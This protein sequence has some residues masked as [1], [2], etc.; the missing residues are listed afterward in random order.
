MSGANP[1]WTACTAATPSEEVC[2]GVDND[3]DGLLDGQDDSLSLSETPTGDAQCSNGPGC[4]GSWQCL[5][6]N[7]S[8]SAQT[9]SPEVC[10]QLDND[11][12]G[13]KDEDFQIDGQYLSPDHCGGCGVA[14]SVVIA[15]SVATS[16]ELLDGNPTCVATECAPGH[17]PF[18]GGLSCPTLPDNLCQPCT[19]NQDCLV[20][21][22]EC[23][24]LGVENVCGRECSATSPY[25]PDC[26]TG[27]ACNG[28]QCTPTGNTCICGT[29]TVGLE[30]SCPTGDCIGIQV[31]EEDNDV[32]AFTSCSAEGVIP[33]VCDGEDNDC[34]GQVDEGFV[35][36]AG[37]YTT[38]EHCGGCYNNCL[39]L[40]TE[41]EHHATGACVSESCE[42]A[43]C[44]TETLNGVTYEW[45][46]V[47][48]QAGDGCECRRVQGN[49]SE[50]LPDRVFLTAGTNTPAF[51]T[52][53]TA[54]E[55]ANCDGVDGVIG[56]AL[57]VTSAAPAGGNGSLET[58]FRTI[59]AAMDAAP[60]A[61][62]Q[63]ILVAGGAYEENI[64]LTEGLKLHGGYAPDFLSRNI[65]T[66]VTEIRGQGPTQNAPGTINAIALNGDETV[67]SGFLITGAD[68]T[69]IGETS[70]SVYVRNSSSLFLANNR[71]VGGSGSPGSPGYSGEIGYGLL[72]ANGSQLEGNNGLNAGSCVS[73][74]CI[75]KSKNGGQAG[76]NPVCPGA[77]GH[78][79]GGVVCP[80]YNTPA[81][82]PADP[83]ID[84]G[85]G[86]SWTLD[87]GS[88]GS[89]TGHATEAGY[90]SNIKK[91]NG[92]DGENGNDGNDGLQGLGCTNALGVLLSSDLWAGGAGSQGATAQDGNPG[93]AGGASGGIDSASASEM[94]PGVNATSNI[95]YKLG[96]TGGGG[97][98]AG[99]GGTGGSGGGTGR[100]ECRC[101]RCGI[102]GPV[103]SPHHPGQS[104]RAR[105][106]R[107]WRHRRLR[108]RRRYRRRRWRRR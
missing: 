3:C 91:L 15:H 104:N 14:C 90:P 83:A 65:V 106:G 41:A 74:N 51:P 108:R 28:G 11:C 96:A 1:G 93:G 67:V 60:L 55:D 29:S 8:C 32:Y 53:E 73:G 49:L 88:F 35:N 98:A 47:N 9:A 40:W 103:C 86:W 100:R 17:F 7:W 58:P 45:V 43:A 92:G 20:P 75:G 72:G 48:E 101:L 63:F 85:A 79:G 102:A 19:N 39:L 66:F 81:Y 50:D 34:D 33:E 94:P 12:D 54:Y 37:A 95:R 22:S 76:A 89:C 69:G 42:I 56:D 99:C 105:S 87:S 6:G 62:K 38:D 78:T 24:D 97:G 2:D 77:T 68:A 13:E 26:P 18:A 44:T 61:G 31:C 23:L 5:G 30:R 52:V 25:G 4:N 82:T 59:G 27:F 70:Y 57:F 71:I 21:G 80:T 64:T 107:R 46:N 84:G 10:D 36:D 16:C